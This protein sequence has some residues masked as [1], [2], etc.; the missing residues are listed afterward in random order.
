MQCNFAGSY[1]TTLPAQNSR[2]LPA[3]LPLHPTLTYEESWLLSFSSMKRPSSKP[4]VL[5]QEMTLTGRASLWKTTTKPPFTRL[6]TL[7]ISGEV[8]LLPYA[9]RH[10]AILLG[11]AWW[12]SDAIP[13][14]FSPLSHHSMLDPSGGVVDNCVRLTNRATS[15]VQCQL[16]LQVMEEICV[17]VNISMHIN[18]WIG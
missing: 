8:L 18:K 6:R 14:Y 9:H 16:N 12:L 13:L 5:A 10:F 15:T 1:Q 11:P 3:A 2:A 17:T 4:L 7:H